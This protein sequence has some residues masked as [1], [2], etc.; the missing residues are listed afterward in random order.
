MAPFITGRRIDGLL[1]M[2]VL[3]IYRPAELWKERI[4][5]FAKLNQQVSPPIIH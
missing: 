5:S 3:L 1:G 4:S 2:D